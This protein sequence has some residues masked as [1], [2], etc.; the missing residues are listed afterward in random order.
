MKFGATAD[1]HI[2]PR[3]LNVGRR[4]EDFTKAAI[5]A[6]EAAHHAG[7]RFL[8]N[9][10][11]TFNESRPS[12]SS[13]Q[14][15][16]EIHQVARQL[17]MPVFLIDGNHDYAEPSWY[18]T[19]FDEDEQRDSYANGGII[20]ITGK[21]FEFEG[22]TIAGLKTGDR[23]TLL[24]DL[25]ILPPTDIVVWHGA[26]KEFAGFPGEAM[27]S[28][29]EIPVGKFQA[30]VCGDIHKCAWIGGQGATIV[31]YPGATELV[32]RDEPLEHF[33]T[34]FDTTPGKGQWTWENIKIPTRRVLVRHARCPEHVDN[35][36]AELASLPKDP[37]PVIL[38]R[39]DADAGGP[40]VKSRL[41]AAIDNPDAV[42]RIS[43]AP[44]VPNI[45]LLG[46]PAVSGEVLKTPADFL[47]TLPH[48]VEMA[49]LFRALCEA[50]SDAKNLIEAWT[51]QQVTAIRAN[52]TH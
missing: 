24:P 48:D 11:D 43:R 44:V 51:D 47:G 1:W 18:Y 21:R 37:W 49:P 6:V 12:S 40:E 52:A 19:I 3:H 29:S 8:I 30:V 14:A 17:R 23:E 50:P 45:A 25:D 42:V 20:H 41:F 2:R 10:G 5:A 46:Q 31:G 39:Y 7:C 16:Q 32:K 36:V 9:G 33:I 34:V 15:L 27:P 26:F 28:V 13:V 4:G 22:L 35:L 38:I